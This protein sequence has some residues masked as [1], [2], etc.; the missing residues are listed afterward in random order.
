MTNKAYI[1]G[2]SENLF[3]D[4]RREDI[5][6]ERHSAY[7]VQRVLEYGTIGDWEL[8]KS[9][10]GLP[11]IVEIAKQLRSLEDKALSYLSV[12]SCTPKESFRCYMLKQSAPQHCNL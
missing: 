8:L 12:I 4:V 5:N 9:H 6:V 7:I 10:Y 3:W 1:L 11:R 2:F